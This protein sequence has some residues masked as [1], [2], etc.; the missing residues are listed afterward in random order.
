MT[1]LASVEDFTYKSVKVIAFS[2]LDDVVAAV[3]IDVTLD[4]QNEA[5]FPS[6]STKLHHTT[7]Y[8]HVHHSPTAC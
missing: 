6:K 5:S 3:A 2:K 7:I 4:N 8:L 1:S